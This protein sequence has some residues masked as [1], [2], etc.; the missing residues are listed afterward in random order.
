MKID[1]E[2]FR[3]IRVSRRLSQREFAKMIGYS[4]G[5]VSHIET[6][7]KNVSDDVSDSVIR[8]F[9]LSKEDLMR[10]QNLLSISK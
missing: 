3:L 10:Y 8:T 5:L 2:L 4:H 6:K 1:N 7:I 9:D